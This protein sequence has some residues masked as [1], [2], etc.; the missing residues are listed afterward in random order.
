MLS[1][2]SE[3]VR[4]YMEQNR[5]E[6]TDFEEA[7]LISHSGLPVL[8]RQELLEKL[9]ERTEDAP[10]REQILARLALDRQE[11][12][13]FRSN[14]GGYVYAVEARDEEDGEPYVCGYFSAVDSAYAHG[15]KRGCGFKID[16][17]RVVGCGD[18][19]AKRPKSYI[20]PHPTDEKDA[21]A[22]V[23]EH[24]YDG[25]PEATAEY[26]AD[27]ALEFF[28]SVGI[29]RT[30]EEMLSALYD[31]AQ[32]ENAFIDVPN[33][34]EH[35]DIVRLTAERE[36]HGVVATSQQSWKDFLEQVKAGKI[37]GVD[38]VDA[39]ITVDFLRSGGRISHE[40]ICPAF[41]ESFAPQ[42]DDADYEVLMSASAVRR[43]GSLDFF[44]MCLEEYRKRLGEA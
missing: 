41:L 44:L 15:M 4:A 35:G 36:A 7:A 9:A 2:I 34:F 32:F 20:N 24:D 18:L 16:K 11:M 23:V 39:S 42:R 1:F 31:P 14:A 33:P 5:L 29:E 6:F 26:G 17:Y 21:G 28:W 19:E 8:K 30:D 25:G 22:R 10:L 37:K 3:D 40:H 13:V 27:G 12:E 38:F 43:G